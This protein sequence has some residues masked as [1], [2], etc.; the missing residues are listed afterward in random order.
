GGLLARRPARTALGARGAAAG[1]LGHRAA[2]GDPRPGVADPLR[3]PGA[4]PGLSPPGG[5][6]RP[7]LSPS[8]SAA[9]P[10]LALRR[11]LR[12]GPIPQRRRGDALL[13]DPV[14]GPAEVH[15]RI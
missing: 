2:D 3:Q 13:V 8:R 5:P 1:A 12:A 10:G 4:G 14:P 7:A 6:D 9:A 15:H 11:G